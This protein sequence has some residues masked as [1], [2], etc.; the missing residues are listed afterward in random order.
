MLQSANIKHDTK[1]LDDHLNL[2]KN[3]LKI[4][5]LWYVPIETLSDN[6]Y[7]NAIS[8]T[9]HPRNL[10]MVYLEWLWLSSGKSVHFLFVC[11]HQ[12]LF[13]NSGLS[14]LPIK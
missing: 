1:C 14:P 4:G 2:I 12:S 7:K 3:K 13:Q 9:R 10:L 5:Y 8:S 6:R 11:H